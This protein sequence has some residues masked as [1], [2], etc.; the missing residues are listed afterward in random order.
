MADQ[1]DQEPSIEEILDSIRQIISDDEDAPAEPEEDIVELTDK[2]DEPAPKAA[3][4]PPPAPPE[5]KEKIIVEMRDAEEKAAAP[6]PP[7]PPPPPSPPPPPPPK[8]EEP[9]P[10][11]RPT[12]QPQTRD[13]MDSILTRHAETAAMD[14]F[15]ELA[16][17]AAIERGGGITI[18][19]V[20]RHE[21][22]P[23]LREWLDRNLPPI[24]ERLLQKEMERISQQFLGD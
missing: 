13:H 22:R 19:D 21:I 15:T 4:A 20:V 6:P 24:V 7:P 16:K 18:E 5:V 2:I 1:P 17:K 3:T 12:P 11:P 23:L 14:A 8:A 9:P 10:A